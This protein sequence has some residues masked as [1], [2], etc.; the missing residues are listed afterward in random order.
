MSLRLATTLIAMLLVASACQST[1]DFD[2]H[3]EP[4]SLGN[5]DGSPPVTITGTTPET[6][7]PTTTVPSSEPPAL[8]ALNPK[9]QPTGVECSV[10]LADFPCSALIDGSPET[11]WQAP[12]RGIGAQ[13]TFTFDGFYAFTQIGFTNHPDNER[14]ESNLRI[15]GASVN[16]EGFSQE[17]V[18][19]IADDNA[20]THWELILSA[21][22]STVTVTV[23]GAHP[24]LG[25]SQPRF[26]EL[27]LA[28]VEFRGIPTR[29]V[30]PTTTEWQFTGMVIDDDGP[31]ICPGGVMDSLPPQCAGVPLD[32]FDWE[33]VTGY[34]EAAG[35]RWADL[36]LVGTLSDGFFRLTQPPTSPQW[37]P[38]I[39]STPVPLPCDEPEGGWQ[40]TNPSTADNLSAAVR[41]AQS[42]SEFMG[43]WNYRNM[44]KVFT[45]TG[46]LEQHGAALRDIYGGPL[47]VSLAD[48]SLAE[49]QA[50]R[51]QV[52]EAIVSD[53]AAGV[54][55]H[56]LDGQYGDTIDVILGTVEFYVLA[57]EPGADDWLSRHF[58]SG[59]VKLHSL[60]QR[61][62]D[63]G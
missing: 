14:F 2:T 30:P 45:F 59:V 18:L 58:D 51:T 35:V 8:P 13:I 5:G 55:I 49:L 60:L 63:A 7:I 56:L 11:E 10:E 48:R 1:T 9:V 20:Q 34:E 61:V 17:M 43:N 32:L 15:K 4:E 6:P 53:E 26:S 16:V 40:V 52:K 25:L 46:N 62:G 31:E 50:I 33:E 27:A 41:Y 29:D 54:G 37:P 3:A 19:G 12:N 22:T 47:C 23:V 39:P 42:Q 21:R 57:V 28:E 36:T 24:S 38:E 44:V